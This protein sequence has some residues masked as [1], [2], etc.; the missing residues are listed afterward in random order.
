L[1]K[2]KEKEKGVNATAL[3]IKV[4]RRMLYIHSL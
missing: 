4:V 1:Q 2:L 3:K